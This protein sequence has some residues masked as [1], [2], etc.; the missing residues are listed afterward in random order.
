MKKLTPAQVR[1]LGIIS[2]TGFLHEPG[3]KTT[4]PGRTEVVLVRLGLVE[5]VQGRTQC[6]DPLYALTPAGKAALGMV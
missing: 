4:N 1:I 2:R 5:Y 6:S 3:A